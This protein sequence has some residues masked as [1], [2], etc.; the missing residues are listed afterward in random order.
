MAILITNNVSHN[1]Y[2]SAQNDYEY[3][4]QKKTDKNNFK[5]FKSD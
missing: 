5:L 4:Q 2:N 1:K 3:L